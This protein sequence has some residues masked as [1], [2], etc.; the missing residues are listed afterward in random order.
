MTRPNLTARDLVAHPANVFALGFGLGLVRHA[1]GTVGTLLG[2]PLFLVLQ[3]MGNT[4]MALGVIALFLFGVWC[5]DTCSR[6][7]GVHDHPGIVW[8]EVVGLLITLFM[9]PLTASAVILGFLYFRLFDILKPWPIGWV[10]A[11]VSGGLGIMLDDVLAG[12]F[13]ALALQATLHWVLPLVL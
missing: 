1:P 10:D 6:N 4:L 11:R 8:D 9:A 3:P 2:L 13:A 12:V 5:C 7:L